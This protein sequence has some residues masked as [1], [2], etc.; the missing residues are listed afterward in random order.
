VHFLTL[1]MCG[2]AWQHACEFPYLKSSVILGPRLLVE[3]T[4]CQL[5]RVEYPQGLQSCPW[6]S[7]IPMRADK[8]AAVGVADSS[9]VGSAC[10]YGMGIAEAVAQID[11]YACGGTDKGP[12]IHSIS[13]LSG[14]TPR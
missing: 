7:V 9:G 13:G 3:F 10:T 12:S 4:G 2:G 1:D 11:N 14:P 5:R 8:N 6:V